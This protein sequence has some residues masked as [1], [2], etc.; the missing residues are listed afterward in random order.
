MVK[1]ELSGP[2]WVT[3]FPGSA[4]LKELS[5]PFRDYASAFVEA[6]R[7][8]GAVVTISATFRPIERAYLMHWAWLIAKAEK[9]PRKVPAMGGVNIQWDHQSED[10]EYLHLPSVDA[11]KAMTRAYG[12]DGLGIAP[13][14]TSRHTAGRAVDMSIRWN[15]PLTI[16]SAEGNTVHILREPRTGMNLELHRVGEAYGVIKYNRGGDDKPHWSD[17]GA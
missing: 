12:I 4:S 5:A 15:G 1:L 14:L 8:A 11:A 13:A 3:R 10:G 2:Q 9:D 16:Q 7:S 17:T 6:L